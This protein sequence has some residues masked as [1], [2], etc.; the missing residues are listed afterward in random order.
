[1]ASGFVPQFSGTAFRR[2]GGLEVLGVLLLRGGHEAEISPILP[3][4]H[5][6]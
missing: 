1:M 4:F 2:E 3:S 6:L 5:I